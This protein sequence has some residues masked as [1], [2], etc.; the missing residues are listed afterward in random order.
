MQI[1]RGSAGGRSPAKSPS[2][3]TGQVWAQR[4]LPPTPD[5]VRATDVFFVPGVRTD[6]HS[7]ERGQFLRVTAGSGLVCSAGEQPTTLE[8]GDVVWVPPGE[9]HWH[10]GS[11]TTCLT[12]LAVS[13][14]DTTWL[15]P[16]SDEEYSQPTVP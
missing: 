1:G 7:H 6:W 5:G 13:F 9:R 15:E 3:F 16:V 4:A 14:G 8:V 12:H 2:T 11:P 10:G